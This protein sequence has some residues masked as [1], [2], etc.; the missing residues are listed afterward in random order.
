[1]DDGNLVSLVKQI[2][3]VIKNE[4]SPQVKDICTDIII[5]VKSR[6]NDQSLVDKYI[7]NLPKHRKQLFSQDYCS[8]KTGKNTNFSKEPQI[9]SQKSKANMSFNSRKELNISVNKEDK[10][11]IRGE[12]KS[13]EKKNMLHNTLQDKLKNKVKGII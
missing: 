6:I 8:E 13:T 12:S 4:N 7:E 1:M 10:S 9:R 3:E 11:R 2:T 5:L